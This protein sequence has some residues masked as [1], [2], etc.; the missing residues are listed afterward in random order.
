MG[1]LGSRGA[2]AEGL[3]EAN[4]IIWLVVFILYLMDMHR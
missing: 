3:R 2:L 1:T 4:V